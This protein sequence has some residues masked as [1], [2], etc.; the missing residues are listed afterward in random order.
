MIFRNFGCSVYIFA[1]LLILVSLVTRHLVAYSEA[2]RS[3]MALI[4]SLNLFKAA[5]TGVLRSSTS[6]FDTT[7]MGE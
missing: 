2:L 4:A 6:F 7:P 3:A 5:L 1:E